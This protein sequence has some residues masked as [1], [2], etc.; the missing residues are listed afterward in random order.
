M[1][2]CKCLERRKN[3]G[4]NLRPTPSLEVEAAIYCSDRCYKR[5]LYHH[6]RLCQSGNVLEKCTVET[7]TSYGRDLADGA[8]GSLGNERLIMDKHLKYWL[9][10]AIFFCTNVMPVSVLAETANAT[11]LPQIVFWDGG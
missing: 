8:F 2:D 3:G 4:E 11:D 5:Q 10:W 9:F 7:I 6:C 1:G